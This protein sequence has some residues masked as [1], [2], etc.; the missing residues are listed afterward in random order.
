MILDDDNVAPVIV[1]LT[2]TDAAGNPGFEFMTGQTVKL[3]GTFTDPGLADTHTVTVHWGDG[4]APIV[5]PPVPV[6]T[7]TFETTYAYLAESF[8]GIEVT[9]ADGD[10]AGT[11]AVKN[12][13][14]S[15]NGESV[16]E[17]DHRVGLVDPGSGK[18]HLY[19]DAGSLATEFFFGNPGDYPFMGDWDG[20]GIETPGLYRQSDGFVYLSNKNTGK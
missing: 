15:V 4:K 13:F 19:N 10:P 16:A 14:V 20:D 2:T 11:S 8:F 17:G 6:G 18:W 9:V 12:A 1:Q 3:S 7:R 5:L